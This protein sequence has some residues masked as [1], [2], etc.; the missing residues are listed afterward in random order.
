MSRLRQDAAGRVYGIGGMMTV[1][2]DQGRAIRAIE[3]P[4]LISAQ[5]AGWRGSGA[6]AQIMARALSRGQLTGHQGDA[7]A[8]VG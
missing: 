5:V 4:W 2:D 8:P 6:G 1:R 3:G 7:P